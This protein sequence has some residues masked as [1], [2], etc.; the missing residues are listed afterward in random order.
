MRLTCDSI[1]AALI[2]EAK[3]KALTKHSL[4]R[5]RSQ[6][7]RRVISSRGPSCN[8][9]LPTHPFTHPPPPRRVFM[10]GGSFSL[11]VIQFDWKFT[12]IYLV[13]CVQR[14][15]RH[16][17]KFQMS[18]FKRVIKSLAF[19]GPPTLMN[20]RDLILD[21]VGE[22]TVSTFNGK[23]TSNCTINSGVYHI[24]CYSMILCD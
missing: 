21:L 22:K 16:I 12:R 19:Y 5:V 15:E 13:C 1:A 4:R 6:T 14:N 20:A 10:I 9:K 11:P 8:K 18:P 24:G 7:N 3:E 17:D 2:K 23:Q